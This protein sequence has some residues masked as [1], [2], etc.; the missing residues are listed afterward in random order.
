MEVW[1]PSADP[2]A[3]TGIMTI[4]IDYQD[5]VE[6]DEPWVT[7]TVNDGCALHP[8]ISLPCQ[9]GEG[10][11]SIYLQWETDVP[12]VWDWELIYN[13]ALLGD[14]IQNGVT[15][16]PLGSGFPTWTTSC[17]NSCRI[18]G[19]GN[20]TCEVQRTV[21]NIERPKAGSGSDV[22]PGWPANGTGPMGDF[23]FGVGVQPI[24][25]G[26]GNDDDTSYNGIV[27]SRG[28]VTQP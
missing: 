21:C 28:Y 20:L 8:E 19:P 10:Q 22:P 14:P 4:L 3:S 17:T 12:G 23:T 1:F 13:P 15:T 26:P 16:S 24:G 5:R 2:S 9:T 7:P 18:F 6:N 27:V 11:V 25:Y